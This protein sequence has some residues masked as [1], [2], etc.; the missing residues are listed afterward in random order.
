MHG[1]HDHHPHH[2]PDDAAKHGHG[3]PFTVEEIEQ[4]HR[5]DKFAGR[6]IISLMLGVFSLGLLGAITICLIARG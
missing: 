1:H 5:D 6:A 4:F 2:P 3:E